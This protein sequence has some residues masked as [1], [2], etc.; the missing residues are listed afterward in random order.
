MIEL[1]KRGLQGEAQKPIRVLYDGENVGDF[2]ADVVVE[3]V[4]VVELKSVTRLTEVHEVQLVN[5]LAATGKPI[6]LLLNFGPERVDVK[7]KYR[8]YRP[9][10]WREEK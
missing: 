7:R 5:H 3:D 6:G 9:N 10:A 2:V 4:I 8:D 1:R